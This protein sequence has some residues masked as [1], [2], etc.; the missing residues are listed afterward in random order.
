[1]Y[2]YYQVVP[3]MSSVVLNGQS[4]WKLMGVVSYILNFFHILYKYIVNVQT[5]SHLECC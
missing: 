2:W 3:V 4:L 1:M 5:V